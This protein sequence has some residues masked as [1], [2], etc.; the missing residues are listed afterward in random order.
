MDVVINDG[1]ATHVHVSPRKEERW[2]LE[3]LKP[4][5][6]SIIYF[7]PAFMGVYA[8]SR[9]NHSLTQSNKKDNYKLKD[10]NYADC[11]KLIDGCKTKDQLIKLMQSVSQA[12][13]AT[14]DYAWN[15]EN[16][17][18][19]KKGSIGASQD[20]QPP[21]ERN[22]NAFPEFRCAPGAT[23]VKHCLIWVE[24]GLSFVHAATKSDT[25]QVLEKGIFKPNADGLQ[26]FILRAARDDMNDKKLLATVFQKNAGWSNDDEM[27]AAFDK[28]L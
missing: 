13:P 21:S 7:D 18:E 6:K 1:C 15:L 16:T 5:A 24:F 25:N 8:P 19:G 22:A 4:I 3:Q 17:Q 10:R 26:E 23:N 12:N 27:W 9:R 14:R 28:M 2:S 11:F 20:S